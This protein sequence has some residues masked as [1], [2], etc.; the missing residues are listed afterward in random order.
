[1]GEET[2]EEL[3]LNGVDQTNYL[4]TNKM[5]IP[6]MDDKAELAGLRKA[7]TTL[8]FSPEEETG[9]FRIS[10]AVIHV[11]SLEFTTAAEAKIKNEDK[12]KIAAELLRVDIKAL[13]KVI[14]QTR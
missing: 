12:L 10:A 2:R 8:N 6:G 9:I 5:D 11:G 3:K 4:K 7:L 13:E 14:V 1:M